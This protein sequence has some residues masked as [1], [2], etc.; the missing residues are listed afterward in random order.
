MG[1]RGR[2]RGPDSFQHA[3]GPTYLNLPHTE[4]RPPPEKEI[5]LP[6]AVNTKTRTSPPPPNLPQRARHRGGRPPQSCTAPLTNPVEPRDPEPK[7]YST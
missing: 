1:G 5:T 7:P 3:P 6:P 4:P 2:S